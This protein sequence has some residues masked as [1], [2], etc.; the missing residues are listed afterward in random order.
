MCVLQNVFLKINLG[1]N[2]V[3]QYI[4]RESCFIPKGKDINKE[5]GNNDQI[6][7]EIIISE[8]LFYG[9]KPKYTSGS[10]KKR[11]QSN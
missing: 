2:G 10:L 6:L 9:F 7:G 5:G 3:C 11:T 4:D 8:K 1:P